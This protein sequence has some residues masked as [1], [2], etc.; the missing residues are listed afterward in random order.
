MSKYLIYK[1]EY[2]KT[3]KIYYLWR[4]LVKNELELAFFKV[5][6]GTKTNCLKYIKEHNIKLN[7]KY[8]K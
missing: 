8:I 5:Y 3:N 7:K 1:I 6:E 4:Y 2:N